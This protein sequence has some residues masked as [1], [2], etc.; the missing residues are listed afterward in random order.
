VAEGFKI[1]DA[2]VDVEARYDRDNVAATGQAAGETAGDGFTR[3]ADG[4]LRDSRGR[5]VKTAD[6]VFGKPADKEGDRHGRRWGKSILGGMG[7]AVTSLGKGLFTD[8]LTGAIGGG[9]MSFVKSPVGLVAIGSLAASLGTTLAAGIA[10]SLAVAF[11]GGLGL[12]FIGLGA[13]LLKDE[14]AIQAGLKRI[15]NTFKN[16]FGKA[17]KDNFLKPMV[18]ALDEIN[19]LIHAI[20]QPIN[21][22][23]KALAPAILPLTRGFAGFIEA[24][25]PGLVQLMQAVGP[26]LAGLEEPLMSM[27]A[28]I[29]GFLARM[30]TDWPAIAASFRDFASDMATLIGLTADAFLWLATHYSQAKAVFLDILSV[31]NVVIIAVGLITKAWQYL[32]TNLPIWLS[33]AGRAV[34]GFFSAVGATVSGWY[35]ATIAWF[36]GAGRAIADFANAAVSY[37]AALPGRIGAWLATLPGIAV[38]WIKDMTSKGLYAIGFMIG[39]WLRFFIDL[40][41][42]I[43]RA[44]SFLWSASTAH[45]NR[46]RTNAM[47]TA[48]STADQVTNFFRAL[49]GRAASAVSGLWSRMS[50]A[51]GSARANA[52]NGTVALVTNTVSYLRTLPGKAASAL[53]GMASRIKGVFAGAGSWLYNAGKALLQGLARGI[54]AAIGGVIAAGKNAAGRI[55]DGIKGA[56]SIGSPSR[57][58]ADEVGRWLPPGITQGFRKALPAEQGKINAMAASVTPDVAQASVTPAAGAGGVGGGLSIGNLTIQVPAGVTDPKSWA[59]AAVAALHQRLNEYE[60]GYA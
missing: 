7:K 21:D 5:F 52:R 4:R 42:N 8:K 13:F 48:R 10:S 33:A 40:P 38:R 34:T 23:F 27:G 28:A 6:E 50:G 59:R 36:Q 1:A 43:S 49:P 58:M 37:L 45:W 3:G 24:M 53:G 57:R 9:L 17:A 12:G 46:M 20:R 19:R 51:F 15:G 60:K 47:N 11:G 41:G 25:M 56:F 44:L 22:I 16:V 18:A 2:Y 39:S 35:R 31:A 54:G 14:P 29:G 32:S 55:I 30:A 26:W